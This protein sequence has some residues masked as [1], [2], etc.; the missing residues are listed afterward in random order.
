MSRTVKT[1][2]H[3]CSLEVVMRSNGWR[4]EDIDRLEFVSDYK[5][6]GLR[7]HYHTYGL[8]VP[9]IAVRKTSTGV[10]QAES[11]YPPNV[12]FPI[13][14]FLRVDRPTHAPP[15]LTPRYSCHQAGSAWSLRR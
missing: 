3:T 1:A 2:N 8:G 4:P 10:D 6:Q 9:L 5:V 15:T 7:N 13:T 11:Y 12:C 14:A